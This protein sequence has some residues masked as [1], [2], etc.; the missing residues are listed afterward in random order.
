MIKKDL[1]EKIKDSKDEDDI[2]ELLKGT[3]VEDAFKV[4]VQPTLDVFKDKLN[5]DKDFKSYMDSE[6]DKHSQKSLET[7]KANNLQTLINDEVLKATGKKKTPQEI[8]ME[9]LEKSLNEEKAA[10]LQ[11]EN[12]SKLKDMLSTA[13]L[14]PVKTI[15]FF[16]IDN[17]EN[18]EKAIGNF[19]AL[20][21]ETV[22]SGVEAKI[23][24]GD[25]TP[26]NNANDG[27]DLG[28][29]DADLLKIMG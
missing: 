17:M 3:D 9:E 16:N 28:V 21:D 7:W 27:G 14:D 19:K 4:E 10:R 26:P 29:S 2:N 25:Y 23:K 6:K 13:G 5:S 22:K 15:E 11:T 24:D 20:I 8:K 1:L 12:T 18:A